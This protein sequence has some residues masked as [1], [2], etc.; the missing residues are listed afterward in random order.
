MFSSLRLV[1]V[2]LVRFYGP[3]LQYREP[4]PVADPDRAIRLDLFCGAK[5]LT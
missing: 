5:G 1:S 2:I 3:T 4:L